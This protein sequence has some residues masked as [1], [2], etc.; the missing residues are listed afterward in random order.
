M[1]GGSRGV[2]PVDLGGKL[3]EPVGHG[4]VTEVDCGVQ[5]D[6]LHRG[7][8]LRCGHLGRLVGLHCQQADPVEIA[9]DSALTVTRVERG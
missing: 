8:V 2:R 5:R 4:A 6:H 9:H 1:R 3:G 7:L